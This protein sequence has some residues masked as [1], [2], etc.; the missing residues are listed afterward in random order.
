MHKFR[1]GVTLLNGVTELCSQIKPEKAT[2]LVGSNASD[3]LRAIMRLER[4][5]YGAYGFCLKAPPPLTYDLEPRTKSVPT[6]TT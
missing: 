5:S 2:K 1:E 6:S 3:L 4:M